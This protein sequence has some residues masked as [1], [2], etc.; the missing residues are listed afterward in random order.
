ML[1]EHS[2]NSRYLTLSHVIDNVMNLSLNTIHGH[3][4]KLLR[5]NRYSCRVLDAPFTG[6]TTSNV[7]KLQAVNHS[8][9]TFTLLRPVSADIRVSK[10]P[11][12]DGLDMLDVDEL[13][14]FL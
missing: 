5:C 11:V 13:A 1:F 2:S 9:G 3:F 8:S 7:L 6:T 10:V 4:L 12:T 14:E